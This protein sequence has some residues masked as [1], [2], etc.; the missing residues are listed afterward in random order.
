M[1]PAQ[2][3]SQVAEDVE[4]EK[5]QN[6]RKKLV[7]DIV[8][9]ALTYSQLY[10]EKGKADFQS[11]LQAIKNAQNEVKTETEAIAT[12]TMA[13]KNILQ[14]TMLQITLEQKL[15]KL[16]AAKNLQVQDIQMED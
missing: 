5:I 15:L 16:E 3:N 6:K 9:D 11:R 2:S 13:L 4:I 14:E 1:K 12:T 8:L 10:K 7:R